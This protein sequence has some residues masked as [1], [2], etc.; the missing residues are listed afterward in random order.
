[1]KAISCD[2][3]NVEFDGN[4]SQAAHLQQQS[5]AEDGVSRSERTVIEVRANIRIAAG[6]RFQAHA[7]TQ[8]NKFF[9]LVFLLVLS[10][11]GAHAPGQTSAS[12]SSNPIVPGDHPDPTIIR[13][14]HTYW[15][16]STS[17]G[18]APEFPLY[19]SDDLRHWT[20]AGAIFP[21]TPAWADTDFWAPELVYD[22]SRVLVY[23]VA[24]KRGGPLCVAVATASAP[25]GPY[26]DHGPIL[27]EPDGSI[28]PSFV[29]DENGQPLLVWKEDGNSERKPTPIWAQPLS[30]DL[31]HLTGSKIQLLVNDPASWEGGVVEAPYILRHGGHFFLFYAGDACCGT[32]CRYAEGVARADR[33]AGPWEKDPAN[34]IIRPNGQWKCP[35]HGTAVETAAGKDYFLYH[36]YPADG[37]VYLG[38]ESVLDAITWTADGWPVINGGNGPSGGDASPPQTAFFDDFRKPMLDPEWKWPIGHPPAF[39]VGGG[40]LTL[41]ASPDARPV[42]V[43]RS[44][45][46]PAYEAEV[47]VQA[48]DTAEAGLGVIGNARS[49]LVLARSG[50]HLQ[51]FRIANGTRTVLW[52]AEIARSPV[53]WLR[54]S[55][56][57]HAEAAFSYSLDHKHWTA[58]APAESVSNLPPWDQGLRI[59]LVADGK[60]GA[61]A[62]FVHFSLV[63]TKD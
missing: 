1:M 10:L 19:R 8:P 16:A 31:L 6:K 20:P 30:S 37:T 28:D 39:H 26:T 22:Q 14:G 54:V 48:R 35:G 38:R 61:Q 12:L 45:L 36:A 56:S 51:L 33:L 2:L 43:A 24:R 40:K 13:V 34:P 18:W 3:L 29:R 58:A 7:M 32:Q 46:S 17:G 47:G 4:H 41:D 62:S 23:Y 57:G 11:L 60:P 55:S 5:S 63:N 53:V 52:Q 49:E 42:F 44:L 25:Q 27:C 21:Q 9:H 15:T 59:G 50:D